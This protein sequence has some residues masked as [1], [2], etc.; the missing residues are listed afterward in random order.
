[1]D[2][3]GRLC[4]SEAMIR[5][6][7]VLIL[8]A[9]VLAVITGCVRVD[10]DLT[11]HEDSTMSGSYL[12][13]IEEGAGEGI[14]VTDQQFAEETL[15]SLQE[16]VPHGIVEAYRQDG[17]V[18]QRAVFERTPITEMGLES[19]GITIDEVDDM[20]VVT[21]QFEDMAPDDGA[22]TL[23]D[24]AAMT[25]SVTFPGP[26]S[27]HNGTVQGTTVTWDLLD[28]PDDG[29]VY[30]TGDAGRGGLPGWLLPVT[31]AIVLAAAIATGIAL[32]WRRP[33]ADRTELE[34]PQ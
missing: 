32:W 33:A 2:R 13:A 9:T 14:G 21:G 23:A 27:D 12:F 20:Y 25:L 16:H 5:R 19:D 8:V 28:L 11:L 17:F 24:S 34:V 30:A 3:D 31:V 10:M 22:S 18:G 4:D 15:A 7:G 26:I 1:M 6:G 29:Q